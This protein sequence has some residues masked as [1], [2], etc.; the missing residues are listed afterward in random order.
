VSFEEGGIQLNSMI[1]LFWVSRKGAKTRS[2]NLNG[3]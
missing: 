3:F 1:R 2:K